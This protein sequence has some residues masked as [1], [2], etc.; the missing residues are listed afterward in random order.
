ME[1][2]ANRYRRA[3]LKPLCT[4]DRRLQ[5]AAGSKSIKAGFNAQR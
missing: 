3:F 2:N 5:A 4:A 1:G